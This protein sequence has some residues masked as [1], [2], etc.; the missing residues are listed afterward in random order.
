MA[1][2]RS[3]SI[4]GHNTSSWWFGALFF[5]FTTSF[6]PNIF[7]QACCSTTTALSPVRL[8]YLEKTGLAF[9][10]SWLEQVGRFDSRSK[11][12]S[13]PE[14]VR[15][16]EFRES[17]TLAYRPRTPWQVSIKGQFIQNLRAVKN[18]SESSMGIGDTD[19]SVRYDPWQ[20]GFWDSPVG[21]GIIVATTI[22]TG[23][24]A[25]QAKKVLASDTT[26]TGYVQFH[27]GLVA[28]VLKGSWFFG[29]GTMISTAPPRQA[30]GHELSMGWISTSQASLA[31]GFAYNLSAALAIQHRFLSQA[32]IDNNTQA[33]G[34]SSN[35]VPLSVAYEPIRF[36]RFWGA[37]LTTPIFDGFGKNE[38]ANVGA[39]LSVLRTW[40]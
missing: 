21:F 27:T 34:A 37:F 28:E 30:N 35:T 26:G 4:S 40:R 23:R 12:H 18:L 7:A 20:T 5:A 31:Y 1:F 17:L 9:G 16:T 14:G 25:E 10:T 33:D 36:W 24:P 39:S 6:S 38:V 8:G 29:V 11:Y 32:S 22:P 2:C 15:D 13:K 3:H 19:V